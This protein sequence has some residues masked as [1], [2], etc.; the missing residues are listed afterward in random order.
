MSYPKGNKKK[1]KP[2][3]ENADIHYPVWSETTYSPLSP[4]TELAKALAANYANKIASEIAA[5]Q[6]MNDVSVDDL[7][8]VFAVA[9]QMKKNRESA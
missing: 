6:P 2:V 5:V 4:P 8:V 1:I 7:A 3:K 9:D